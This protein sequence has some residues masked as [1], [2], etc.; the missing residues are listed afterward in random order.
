MRAA[1]LIFAIV[2]IIPQSAFATTWRAMTLAETVE[3]ANLIVLGK[4]S[5]RDNTHP[6]GYKM[7]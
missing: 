1:F 7:R 5:G 4:V 6:L 2:I 3:R